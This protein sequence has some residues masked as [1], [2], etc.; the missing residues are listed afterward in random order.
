MGYTAFGISSYLSIH[1]DE[2]GQ[3]R[4]RIELFRK[5]RACGRV[6][7]SKDKSGGGQRDRRQV[8][9]EGEVRVGELIIR[10]QG[11]CLPTSDNS[12]HHA[13][14]GETLSSARFQPSRSS[15][16]K[17]R[18]VANLESRV[19]GPDVLV[20]LVPVLV[21]PVGGRHLDRGVHGD[22]L[23]IVHVSKRSCQRSCPSSGVE[24]RFDEKKGRRRTCWSQMSTR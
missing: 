13:L 19:R 20:D 12:T 6:H 1:A 7:E 8:A 9:W 5:Q 21:E 16:E 17:R 10:D 3:L 11:V 14:Q 23:I 4:W 22:V 18:N 2:G 24:F 15:A